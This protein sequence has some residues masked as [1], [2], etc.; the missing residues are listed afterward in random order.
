[1]ARDKQKLEKFAQALALGKTPV[2]AAKA[3]GYPKGSSFAAI[4]AHRLSMPVTGK[5]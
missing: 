2:E 5:R 1:M 4:A 3:A